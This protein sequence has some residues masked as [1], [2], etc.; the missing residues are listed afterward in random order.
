MFGFT[1]S[2]LQSCPFIKDLH[3]SLDPNKSAVKH[4]FDYNVDYK[5]GHLLKV[6]ITGITGSSAEFQLIEYVLA[7]SVVLEKLLFQCADLDPSSELKVSREL[8]QLPRASTKAKLVC[9]KQ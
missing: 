9:L 5:L 3:I 2:I 1:I 7:T 4:K 8:L 6:E